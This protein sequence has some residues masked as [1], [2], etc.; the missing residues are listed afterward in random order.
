ML[1]CNTDGPRYWSEGTVYTTSGDYFQ[2]TRDS[3]GWLSAAK[4]SKKRWVKPYVLEGPPEPGGPPMPDVQ[5]PS[6]IWRDSE[7]EVAD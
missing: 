3:P 5:I 4:V 7:I 2:L 6:A 1:S